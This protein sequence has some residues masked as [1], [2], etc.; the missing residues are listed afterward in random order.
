MDIDSILIDLGLSRLAGKEL[1]TIDQAFLTIFAAIT[2][3]AEVAIVPRPPDLDTD[4]VYTDRKN[5]AK[6]QLFLAVSHFI[7]DMDEEDERNRNDY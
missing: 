4:P 7:D 5:E 6:K 3:Y 1:A 2:N